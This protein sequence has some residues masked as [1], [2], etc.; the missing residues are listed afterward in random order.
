MSA[1]GGSASSVDLILRRVIGYIED[2]DYILHHEILT[3]EEKCHVQ[4]QLTE[5]EVRL[6]N[7]SKL[8]G[9]SCWT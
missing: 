6:F 5:M 1:A 8:V 9:D 7:I 2:V 4:Q 3:T